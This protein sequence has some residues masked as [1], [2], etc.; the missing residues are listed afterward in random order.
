MSNE[1]IFWH[2]MRAG[3]LFFLALICFLSSMVCPAIA[4]EAA[5]KKIVLLAGTV[6]QGPGGHPAGT[7]EYELTAR[8]LKHSLAEA[9][10]T[11]QV[12]IHFDGW[13]RDEKTLDDADTIVVISD[14]SDRNPADHPLLVGDR[15]A[16]L[17]KQ[18]DRGCGLIAIHWSTFMPNDRGGP[19]FLKWIGGYFDYQSGTGER[20]WFSKIQTAE[21]KPKPASPDHP[22]S[23]GLQPFDLREEY[24]YNIR[25][26]PGDPIVPILTTPIP[27]EERE[28]VVAWAV[29]RDNGG[30]GFGFTGG[31]FF[32]NWG[33]PN[34]RRMVLNAILWTAHMDVPRDGAQ[35]APPR[36]VDPPVGAGDKPIQAVIVTGHQHPAHLWRE[37]TPALQ[38]ALA[39][40]KRM[41]ITVVTDPEFLAS[42]NLHGYDVVVLNYCNWQ[43]PGLSDAAK[44]N[45]QKYL[46]DGG[47]LALIHFANGAFH[48]S[49]PETPPSDWPEYRNICRRIWDHAPGK[50]GHDAYGHFQVN[51]VQ[52]HPITAG[53]NSFETIDELYCN[54]QGEGPIEV[55][56]TARSTVTGRDE[57]LAFV[58]PYGKGRIFQTVLGHAAESIRTPGTAALIRRGA[59]WAADQ[60]QRT[61]SAAAPPA[62][63]NP[64]KL[65]EAGKFD[66]ALDPRSGGAAWAEHK[67]EYVKRPL[68]VECWAKLDGKAGFNILAASTSKDSADHWELYTYAGSGELSLYMPGCAPAE[69]KSG[70]DVVDGQWHYL[71]AAFDDVQVKLF[72][73]GKLVHQATIAR[74]RSGGPIA[75]LHFGGYPPHNIGCDGLVDEVRISS[76]LR[77]IDGIPTAP[78]TAGADTIGLWHFDRLDADWVEDAS[79]LKNAA[80]S[81]SHAA[82]VG[83]MPARRPADPALRLTSIDT[84]PDES[85][86]SLRTDTTGRLFAGGRE[87]LFVYDVDTAGG[88]VPRQ[89]LYRFPPDT[90]VTDIE[91]RG[92]DLYAM[93]N[94][95][96]YRFVGGRV[97]RENLVPQ[98]LLWGSPVDLHVTW[99]GLAWGPEGDL[100]FSSGDPLLNYGD[101]QKRPDHWGHWT[102]YGPN[103]QT[104]YTGVGGFYRCKP[105]GSGLQV[106]AGG[107]RGAVG[108]A[109]DRRWNLFSNDN[110]H[111]SIADRYSPARLLH[112]APQAN[113]FWPR[114]WI[115]GMSPERSDL[116]EMVNSDIGREVPVGQAYL[117]EPS[118][119]EKYTDSILVARWGQRRVSGYKLTPRGASFASEEYPLLVGEET[120]RPV[121]VTV[122]RGGRVFVAL[123]YMA[124]NEWSPKYPSEIVMLSRADEAGSDSFDP[125]DAP[126]VE[127]ARLWH[128]LSSDSSQQRQQAQVELLRRGG[129]LLS[130]AA[131]RLARC[132]PNDPALI[133][134][135]WLSAA[136]GTQQ[137]RES[138][139]SLAT[140]SDPNIRA[141]V[142]RAL[143]EFP[144]LGAEPATFR[145]ALTDANAAVRHAAIVALFDSSA[146]LPAEL[147]DGPARESDTYLRQ[148]TAL[149]VAR[150]GTMPQLQQ[151][152]T[153]NDAAQRLSGVLAA[154]FKL[155]VPPAVGA[156]PAE[157]PLKYESG[158]AEFVLQYADAKID[159]KSL[160]RVGS[161]T[162]AERWK[163]LPPNDEEK[164]LYQSLLDRLADQDERVFQQAAYFLNLFDVPQANEA[165]AKTRRERLLKQLAAAPNTAVNEA[166]SIGPFEDR[167][168]GFE[169][170][171]PPEEGPVD[172]SANVSADNDMQT[173]AWEPVTFG[174]K[175]ASSVTTL[176][177]PKSSYAYF[178][179]QSLQPQ[180]AQL[181]I[182]APADYKL[183]HNGRPVELAQPLIVSL[184]PGSN[185]FLVRLA[186]GPKGRTL[187][188][189]VRA[190]DRVEAMLPEKLALGTLA[191]RLRNSASD[192]TT[193]PTEFLTVDWSVAAQAGDAERGRRLFGADALGC[194]KCHA[195]LPNQK[196]GGAPSLAGASKRF[197]V[198]HLVESVLAPGK[199]V[200]PVF[201]TTTIIT[202]DGQSLSGLVVE[203]S[204]DRV[205]LLLPTAARQEVAKSGIEVRKLQNASPMPS[206][207]VKTPAELGDLLAYLLGENPQAP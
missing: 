97:R 205:V 47:G 106:V 54:Q 79:A 149:L 134:L 135:I 167:A 15:L 99:H 173:L 137:A 123:S 105:D 41:Q 101:F 94:A 45:F 70:V 88:Y 147:L 160:G 5:P 10:P 197:T 38:E 119:G 65:A 25:F 180:P 85:F 206:G 204:D 49:L 143:H 28:Q 154:G 31:H 116:L 112:V 11:S 33:I 189:N 146:P 109:F 69:V 207:L 20:P 187:A 203:E 179:L 175:T 1:R 190:V 78:F 82:I 195:M 8:L 92:D 171:H 87:G 163:H 157:L 184:D 186:H 18:M 193:V 44:A 40:D 169:T 118:L 194:V 100:Y 76:T 125:Y 104:S 127:P 182:A 108:V 183:W 128:E 74:L 114:G 120:A 57:P 107:T 26:S 14:G 158:N 42:E 121:G 199:Q 67:P 56:A 7:H 136:S 64:P 166:W 58:Y 177:E 81:G 161:F 98:R 30:R 148:A 12:E 62:R 198:S 122:G 141:T 59:V 83:P 152:L 71:A 191:E 102:I 164:L 43:R 60:P 170:V 51:V 126:T 90:W 142:V 133:P 50:S 192:A 17:K 52:D 200:A 138:L 86:L 111:E 174:D 4:A 196:G 153:S 145:R 201:G 124:G 132:S 188:V 84:S 3:L 32:E 77:N 155:T 21:T 72:V 176:S 202:A 39:Q 27:G 156:L 140:S 6:H 75:T 95:A 29:E 91:I 24:Y 96:L 139:Q 22:I 2:A 34:F 181:D 80:L 66:A 113:F 89:L 68:T 53:L 159:L 103:E 93:T 46:A 144:K 23:R 13:P 55:L 16:V 61:L 178:R 19:E 185:D 172:L 115:A 165:V 73:D 117:D 37:T 35:S 129:K 48:T 36:P 130:E 162:T 9:A 150:R 151:L 110:D 131:D 63:A 168:Q